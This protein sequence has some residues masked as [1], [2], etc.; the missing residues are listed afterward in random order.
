[1]LMALER[2]EGGKEAGVHVTIHCNTLAPKEVKNGG[3]NA[4]CNH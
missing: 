4:V 2:G 1:M 3:R